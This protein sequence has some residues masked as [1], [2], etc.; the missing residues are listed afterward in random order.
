MESNLVYF[1]KR[2]EENLFH[3]CIKIEKVFKK[4]KDIFIT[5]DLSN[6]SDKLKDGFKKLAEKYP[7]SI[8]KY[9]DSDDYYSTTDMRNIII[10]QFNLQKF[11]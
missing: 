5:Y 4:P 8:K 9:K 7:E 3:F 6:A 10:K 1:E 2:G 11:L